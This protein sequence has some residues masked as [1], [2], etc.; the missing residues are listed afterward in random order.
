VISAVQNEHVARIYDQGI[1]DD[2]RGIRE[3]SATLRRAS[4]S[5]M[6]FGNA[7]VLT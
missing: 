6:D 2:L 1:T 5:Q 4:R 3:L 7:V